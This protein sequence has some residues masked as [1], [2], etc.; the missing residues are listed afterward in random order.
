MEHA[1]FTNYRAVLID[2]FGIGQRSCANHRFACAKAAMDAAAPRAFM[3][4]NDPFG[5]GEIAMG[6]LQTIHNFARDIRT[7][8]AVLAQEDN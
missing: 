5:P 7:Y 4:L 3:N 1:Q 8:Q 2:P 6:A